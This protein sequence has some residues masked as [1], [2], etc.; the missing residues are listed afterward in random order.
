MSVL[1]IG[2][3]ITGGGVDVD[4]GGWSGGLRFEFIIIKLSSLRSAEVGC[5]LE[6][7]QKQRAK[8][9]A[10]SRKTQRQYSNINGPK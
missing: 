3:G 10:A 8:E 1:A 7:P 2:L 9:L 5:L 6:G 4:V